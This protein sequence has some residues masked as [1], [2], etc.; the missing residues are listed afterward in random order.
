VDVLTGGEGRGQAGVSG[1]M[2]DGPKLHLV[3]VGHEKAPSRG[4]DEGFTEA[5][6][7]L[8]ADGDVVEVGPVRGQPAGAGH[9]LTEGGVDPPVVS[10]LGGQALP[11][12]RA[13][14]LDLA[15]AEQGLDD[16]V[17]TPQLLECAG[18]GGESGLGLAHRGQASLS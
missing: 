6:A 3:V 4:R 11:V 13:Q 15:V 18:V 2:G 9:G 17:L 16:G 5:P 1:Q 10:H 7:L 12:G 14:L 8:G